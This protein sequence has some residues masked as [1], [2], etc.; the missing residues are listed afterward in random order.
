MGVG[1]G[2]VWP[3]IAGRFLWGEGK[4]QVLKGAVEMSGDGQLLMSTEVGVLMQA[5]SGFSGGL[6]VLE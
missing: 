1:R 3:G 5:G 6:S 2:V 4:S